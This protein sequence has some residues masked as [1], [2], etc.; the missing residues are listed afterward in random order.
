MATLAAHLLTDL[1]SSAAAEIY[2]AHFT[3][4]FFHTRFSRVEMAKMHKE[5][6]LIKCS[7][8][9]VCATVCV[10]VSVG[11]R[12][13]QLKLKA[14]FEQSYANDSE[15]R[16]AICEICQQYARYINNQITKC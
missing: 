1:F 6:I 9:R 7:R 13:Q 3:V 12:V 16:E 10:R 8:I 4:V 5:N 2:A 11:V 15:Q 14:T